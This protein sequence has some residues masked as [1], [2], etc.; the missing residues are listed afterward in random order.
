MIFLKLLIKNKIDVTAVTKTGLN[1]VKMLNTCDRNLSKQPVNDLI[2][3]LTNEYN[4]VISKRKRKLI[5]TFLLLLFIIFLVFYLSY[6]KIKL[7]Y[8]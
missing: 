6:L 2:I 7:L 4:A 8:F 1:A 5:L 3:F